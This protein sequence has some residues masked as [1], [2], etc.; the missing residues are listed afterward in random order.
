MF[1]I[2]SG[3]QF[4]LRGLLTGGLAV[5]GVPVVA[6]CFLLVRGVPA[7][8]ISGRAVPAD[9]VP[10]GLMAATELPLVIAITER[11]VVRGEL[12]ETVATVM[13]GAAMLSVFLF[14][15]IALDRRRPRRS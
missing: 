9:R 10:L 3:M 15:P 6:A 12:P 13:V 1:F 11:G 14:P 2:V 5:L 8:L 7:A 4:D